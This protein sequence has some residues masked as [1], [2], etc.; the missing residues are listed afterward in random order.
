[1]ELQSP[2]NYQ[3]FQDFLGVLG[4]FRNVSGVLEKNLGGFTRD[5]INFLS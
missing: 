2:R 5:Y 4:I 1:L 3:E